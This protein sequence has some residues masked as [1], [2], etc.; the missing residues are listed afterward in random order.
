MRWRVVAALGAGYIGIYLCRKNLAVAIPMLQTAWGANR[1]ELGRV[2]SVGTLTYAA[3]KLLLGP[4]ADRIGGNVAFLIS[5][6]TVA[7]FGALG[8]FFPSVMALTILYALNRFFGAG[9]WPAM[10]KLVPTWFPAEKT[11]FVAAALSLSYVLGGIAATLFAREMVRFGWHA[12]LAA[13]SILLGLI[14][15][16][17]LFSVRTGPLAPKA[18]DKQPANL[19]ALLFRPQFIVVCVL[20]FTLTLLRESFNVWSVDFLMSLQGG[21]SVKAAALQST[22]FDLAGAGSILV[23]GVL[24]DRVPRP[25][26]RWLIA[27]ILLAL[28]RSFA[29]TRSVALPRS[30]A[31]AR[32]LDCELSSWPGPRSCSLANP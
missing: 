29:L 30:F 10:M 1:A 19:R 22:T 18:K 7:L 27:G 5:L 8:G 16:G 17:C 14:A 11:A 13:P 32:S 2:A 31:L 28:A 25:L 24:Y 4:L 26:R 12:V 21:Q 20:S 6:V 3:G 15:F 23:M 9:G